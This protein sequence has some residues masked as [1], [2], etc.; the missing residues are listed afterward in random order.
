MIA[1]ITPED[2]RKKFER[3]VGKAPYRPMRK[4]FKFISYDELYNFFEATLTY[5]ELKVKLMGND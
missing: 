5:H 3:E 1:T 2:E 4:N